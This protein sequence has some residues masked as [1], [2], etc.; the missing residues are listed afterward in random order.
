[1][2]LELLASHAQLSDCIFLICSFPYVRLYPFLEKKSYTDK[3]IQSLIKSE[4]KSDEIG[5]QVKSRMV[6]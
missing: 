6:F 1:M 3:N 4:V 2:T 5:A